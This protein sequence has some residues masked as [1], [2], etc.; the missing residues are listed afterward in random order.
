MNASRILLSPPDVGEREEESVLAALRSGWAAPAGPEL[1][2]FEREVADRLGVVNAV[3]LSS[4]TAALH[5]G[6]LALG[7]GSGDIV[8][9]STLTFAA[10]ANAIIYTGA[11][12]HFVDVD[13]VDGNMD[14]ALLQ[15]ALMGLADRGERVA[16]IVPVDLLGR[17]ADYQEL[18]PIAA[19][20]GVPVFADAAESLG[21]RYGGRAAGSFGRAAALSFNGNKIMT[22]SGGGMLVSDDES[23]VRRARHLST[24]AREPV[25]HY[26]HKDVGYNY[27]LSNVLAAIGRA[28]LTRL[29]LMLQ[30]RR[31][32]RELYRGLFRDADG[33][34]IFQGLADQDDN[35]WLTA[36]LV[37]EAV[38]WTPGDLALS[39]DR[40]GIESRPLW[41]PLH[42]QPAYSSSSAT[43]SGAAERLFRVGLTLPSGSAMTDADLDRIAYAIGEFLRD[44]G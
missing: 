14:P 27:R 26:E 17:S 33:V 43:L 40:A 21:A 6:L 38:A 31:R 36:V 39:L 30:S 2:A 25:H 13:P 7:V 28:Q 23:I 9:T 12:P 20:A 34:T 15:A 37:D 11:R 41:K 8:V 22:T 35:C 19:S 18:L 5:L 10:T 4:G 24:Q 44:R 42:L 1:A 32:V 3:A 16:A 29:D